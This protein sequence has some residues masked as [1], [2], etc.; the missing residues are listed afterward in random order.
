[1]EE[2]ELFLLTVILNDNSDNSVLRFALP[3]YI[4]DNHKEYITKKYGLILAIHRTVS[5][6]SLSVKFLNFE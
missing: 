3:C 1:M 2:K 4:N 5:E 6:N